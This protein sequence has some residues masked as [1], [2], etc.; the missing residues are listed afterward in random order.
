MISDDQ[1]IFTGLG[2]KAFYFGLI[3]VGVVI[4]VLALLV[5][6]IAYHIVAEKLSG[7]REQKMWTKAVFYQTIHGLGI[8]LW[9]VYAYLCRF[10]VASFFVPVLWIFGV[11]CFSGGIYC[12]LLF[13]EGF[14]HR[15]IPWG[16]MG[17]LLGWGIFLAIWIKDA[18]NALR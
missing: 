18:K 5:D 6:L 8:L 2:L 17:Y 14:W 9:G 12:L 16:G 1:K 7:L 4:V 15:I 10:S 3:G 13:G 11:L